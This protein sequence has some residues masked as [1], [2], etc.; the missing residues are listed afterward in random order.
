MDMCF[1]QQFP[2]ALPYK[3]CEARLSCSIVGEPANTW[4]NI[5]YLIAAIL[6]YRSRGA[7]DR[8]ARLL[9]FFTTLFLFIGSTLLHMSGTLLGRA[10][11]WSGMY[12][13]SVCILTLSFERYLKMKS[14]Q[15][16]LFFAL[17]LAFSLTTFFMFKITRTVFI[18]QLACA[19]FLEWRMSRTPQALRLT[20]VILA[21]GLIALAYVFW[22]LDM[23]K[24]F[25]FPDNHV[26]SGHA[27]WHLLAAAS[28][29]TFFTSYYQPKVKA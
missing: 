13:V 9:F 7:T 8:R 10:L 16:Y 3:F 14:W 19:L 5:G 27:I 28:I 26:L 12:A 24:I 25:C 15:V 1:W 4:S 2:A 29:W 20:R 23:E 21:L 22:T 11:D 17:M 6:I 18:A